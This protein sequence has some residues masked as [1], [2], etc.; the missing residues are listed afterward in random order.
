MF[1]DEAKALIDT[2]HLYG[3]K[4]AVHAHGVEGINLAL[5]MGADSI[6]HGTIFDDE[7]LQLLRRTR[8]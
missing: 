1:E 4:V 8:A 5:R 2:A 6:E 7:T 3:K